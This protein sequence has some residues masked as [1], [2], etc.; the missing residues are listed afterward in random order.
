[1]VEEH[2]EDEDFGVEILGRKVGMSR[3][4]VHRKLR[5]LTNQSP[6]R[7]IRS[8]RLRRAAELL[9]NKAGSVAEIAYMVGF[10]S[11]GYFTTCFR[12]QF[13]C[14]PKEYGRDPEQKPLS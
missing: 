2:L 8:V 3:S 10:S 1:M 7:F 14:T 13:G 6:S 4:Q 12:E 5:A 11:Q 9:Q